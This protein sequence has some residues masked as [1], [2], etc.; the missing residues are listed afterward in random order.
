MGRILLAVAAMTWVLMAHGEE[1]SCAPVPKGWQAE[2]KALSGGLCADVLLGVDEEG[3]RRLRVFEGGQM[4]FETEHAALCKT[5]G[6]ALGDPF[7]E[8]EWKNQTLAVSNFG[9]SRESWGETWKFAKRG[10]RWLLAGWEREYIDRALGDSWTESVNTLSGRAEASF[11]PG[12]ESRRKPG[13]ASC[14][15]KGTAPAAG[16]VDAIRENEPFACGM[17]VDWEN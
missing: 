2:V 6:G 1:K 4:A 11:V 3:T 17:K 10:G 12:A 5:C 16:E 13:S 9:G 8:I 7:Q 14:A 15:R